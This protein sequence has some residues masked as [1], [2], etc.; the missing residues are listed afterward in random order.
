MRLP[1]LTLCASAK[2][3]FRSEKTLTLFLL[4]AG[5]FIDFYD[6]TIMGVSYSELIQEKF[7]IINTAQI[8]QT[9]L[10]ISNF[11]T[12]GIFIGAILF[13]ILGDKLGRAKAV[14]YSILL[15]S[16]STIVSV[17]THSLPVFIILRV[18]AYA[19]LAS[20]FATSTVLILELFPAKS[21]AWGTAI[22]YS[23]GVL[24]GILATSIGTVSWK[25]MF[26]FGGFF[27][28]A[29]YIGRSKIQESPLYLKEKSALESKKLGSLTV[30]LSSKEYL[31]K[32]LRYFL[33]NLPFYAIITMM[34]IFPNYIIKEITLDQ[35]M[36]QLLFGFFCGNIISSLL[37]GL[38]I[39]YTSSYKPFLAFFLVLFLVLMSIFSIIPESHLFLYSIGLGC[40][41]GGYPILIAQL[42]VR[43]FPVHIRSLASNTLVAMGR[44][45]GI[46]FNI[47]MSW[48]LAS[49]NS[50]LFIQNAI[51]TV[52]IIFIMAAVSL[53][54]S[55]SI[56]R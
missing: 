54:V 34:F 23:F 7:H 4:C 16:I 46:F 51:I 32:L 56:V 14:R 53:G 13:G 3:L 22:L 9:Y 17:Y 33:M 50:H 24:G 48:W 6:L 10:L 18:V 44:S 55:K 31:T 11:Q 41:G 25:A 19:G 35:A 27:G 21:A 45:S 8:Q 15:Y 12:L 52:G 26:L 1:C 40:L 20:E 43:E 30:L 28:L 47:L 42:A 29:L 39:Q 49:S 2:T 5:Y 37:S 38:Y 36:K